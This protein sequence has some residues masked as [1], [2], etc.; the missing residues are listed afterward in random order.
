MLI[1]IRD[2]NSV[3]LTSFL[4]GIL[5]IMVRSS[6]TKTLFVQN[7][8]VFSLKAIGT[9]A[10]SFVDEAKARTVHGIMVSTEPNIIYVHS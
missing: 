7:H 8:D 5:D 3:G 1:V 9:S 2:S 10:C 6:S 4:K